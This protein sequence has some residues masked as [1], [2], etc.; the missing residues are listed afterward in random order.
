MKIISFSLLIIFYSGILICQENSWNRNLTGINNIYIQ[1]SLCPEEK[2]YEYL[3]YEIYRDATL[4]LR[5]AGISLSENKDSNFLLLINMICYEINSKS[6]AISISFELR[7]KVYIKRIKS[8]ERA[9]LYE[10]EMLGY[11]P[12]GIKGNNLI[13][14][15]IIN[16]LKNFIL[17]YKLD[18]P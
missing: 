9:N 15:E 5:N 10:I 4:Y 13:K 17:D 16:T 12:K 18:N 1:I 11:Y 6:N 3:Q 2:D 14:T 7:E 8:F